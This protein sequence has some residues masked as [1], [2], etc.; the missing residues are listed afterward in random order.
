MCPHFAVWLLAIME[1]AVFYTHA[2]GVAFAGTS[3]CGSSQVTVAGS[4]GRE[5]SSGGL[6]CSAGR[7]EDGEE[8]HVGYEDIGIEFRIRG[9]TLTS[10]CSGCRRSR[11][12][13]TDKQIVCSCLYS[14]WRW[15]S[16]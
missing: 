1:I 8:L 10:L 7:H 4:R 11:I 13:R 14:T 3:Q 5:G 16:R 2:E 15:C 9:A 6:Q 12:G